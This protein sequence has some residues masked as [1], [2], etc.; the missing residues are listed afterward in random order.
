MGCRQAASHHFCQSNKLFG[1]VFH[2]VCRFLSRIGSFVQSVFSRF[3]Y[4][5]FGFGCRVFGFSYSFP[6]TCLCIS[7]SIFD[8]VFRFFDGRSGRFGGRSRSIFNIGFNGLGRFFS[9]LFGFLRTSCQGS[10]HHCGNQ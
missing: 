7:R 8:L 6:G 2:F 3:A 5:F 10:R 9:L 4:R 1:G